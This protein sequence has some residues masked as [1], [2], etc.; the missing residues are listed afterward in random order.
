MASIS[1][2][3]VNRF[4]R[5]YICATVR[6]TSIRNYRVINELN[7]PD[8]ST[9]DKKSQRF[10]S[11]RA[12]DRENNVILDGI[13][14]HYRAILQE[15]EFN[16]GKE[17]FEYNQKLTSRKSSESAAVNKLNRKTSSPIVDLSDEKISPA[18]IKKELTLGEWIKK[19]IADIK[20]PRR[21]KP[22]ASYQ[23][24]LTLLHKLEQEDDIIHQ[25]LSAIDDD[26]Y[27]QLIRWLN[28]KKSSV[29]GKGNNS[30]GIM[31]MFTATLNRAKRARLITY[32]PDF[33]YMD[34][35]PTFQVTDNA[36]E[37]LMNGGAIKSMTAEQYQQFLTLDLRKIS[38]ARGARNYSANRR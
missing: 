28:R 10:V 13:M 23:G 14:A 12:N 15:H 25:P 22:S 18:P 33:P 32:H 9:W 7:D 11:R 34:F 30:I 3:F 6:K 20:V 1:L 16:N 29:K 27:K 2:K 8:I 19:I 36:K 37:F 21:L 24:Y 4:G 5:F 31:K 35:A 38:M 17:L 26:S